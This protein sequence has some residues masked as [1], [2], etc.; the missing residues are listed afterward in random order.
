MT[1]P[2]RSAPK[3]PARYWL[4]PMLR[5]VRRSDAE[6]KLLLEKAAV[7]AE[8]DIERLAPKNLVRRGQFTAAWTSIKRTLRDLFDD[9]QDVV[10]DGRN[11]AAHAAMVSSYEWEEELYEAAGMTEA[12]KEALRG[13]TIAMS[14]RNVE[15]MLRRFNA[16]QIPLSQ[17][18]YR[19]R[20]LSQG[21]V[22]RLINIGIGRGQTAR[23]LAKSV[24]QHIDPSVRGGVAYAAMRLA[25]TEINN[26]F[27]TAAIV[28]AQDKPW[29]EGMEWKLSGSHPKT[30]I[31]DLLAGQIYPVDAVPPKP[32]PQC[33][34]YIIPKEPDEDEFVAAFARGDYD[35]ALDE[36]A[37]QSEVEINR[38]EPSVTAGKPVVVQRE[39]GEAAL[40]AI[41]RALWDPDLDFF[42]ERLVF[43]GYKGFAYIQYNEYLRTGFGPFYQDL[44]ETMDRVLDSSPL[45]K[46]SVFWRGVKN[47]EIMFGD[48]VNGDL[49]GLEW[50]DEAYSSM[51]ADRRV[52]DDFAIRKDGPGLRERIFVPKG[53]PMMKLSEWAQ[54]GQETR[55]Y[56]AE[57]L[58]GRGWRK[59]II[60]DHGVDVDGVRNID[61]EVISYARNAENPW[62]RPE[63]D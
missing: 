14:D 9:V 61:V 7:A 22:D 33:F 60:A 21:W 23:E 48:A 41:P 6:I 63:R 8:A 40:N 62:D 46:E 42:E 2:Q 13:G 11:D 24:R 52:A 32:H 10:T 3:D 47:P 35:E 44:I 17:Q 39:E 27:H 37:G 56:E 53:A 59:R 26:S 43:D 57:G 36:I 18:V 49:T 50:I 15:L 55:V 1:L 19:T 30:D 58:G 5:V 20:A 51:S 25:R 28:A 29:I 34:C 4:H 12:E 16:E 38:I 45:E 54:E 31:C